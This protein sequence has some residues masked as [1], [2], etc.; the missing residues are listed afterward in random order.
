MALKSDGTVWT[1]GSNTNGQLGIG[2]YTDNHVPI[3]VSGLTGVVAVAAGGY[4]VLATVPQPS[5]VLSIA[6]SHTGSFAQ[7]QQGATYTITVTNGAGAGPTS[8]TVTV[9][10]TLPAG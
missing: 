4:H 6:K 3:Q 9:I 2:T 5:P 8:G 7:G 10:D 1:W